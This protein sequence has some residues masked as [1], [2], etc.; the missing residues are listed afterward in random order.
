MLS[1]TILITGATSGIGTETALA[2]AKQG[3]VLYLLV[4]DVDKGEQLKSDL[5]AQTKNEKINIVKCDLTDL[6]SVHNAATQIKTDLTTIHVLI[7]NAGGIFPDREVSKDGFEMTFALNHLGHFL[8]TL[9]LMLLLQKGHARI[10]NVSSE[11]HRMAKVDFKDLQLQ[12]SYSSARAYANAKLFNIYFTRSLAERF[13]NKG[14]KA[15][16]LHP[17]IVNT[18]FGG[19]SKGLVKFLLSLARPFMISPEKG[20]LTTVFLAT[21]PQIESLSGKYF[22]NKK[23][24]G[25]SSASNNNVARQELWVQSEGFIKAFL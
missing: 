7:N 13:S 9:S 12:K 16:C 5:I 25:T 4:R 23:E 11:A 6:Q 19:Q 18:G 15:Y 20:A 22:K 17:G 1:K 2:L 21:A 8:L 24:A 3:H 14:V 10:I